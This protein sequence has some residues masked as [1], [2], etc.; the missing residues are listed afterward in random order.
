M[1]DESLAHFLDDLAADP[2]GPAAGSAAAIVVA[3]AAALVELA[4]RRSGERQTS[5]RA[6]SLRA[7]VGPLAEADARAFE[8]VLRSR[9][10]ERQSALRSATR[11]LRQIAAAA[12][13]VESL[14]SP[15]VEGAKPALSGEAIAAVE[16]AQAARRVSERLIMINAGRNGGDVAS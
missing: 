7:R 16:L 14:A 13:A 3:M 5:S 4:A 9:G 12:A 11:V 1:T 6:S 15:L 2:P 8:A 10:D